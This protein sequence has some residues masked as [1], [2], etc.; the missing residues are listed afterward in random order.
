MGMLKNYLLKIQERVT[1]H[2]FG[3][4]AIEHAAVSGAIKITGSLEEDV[5]RFAQAYDQIC[6]SYRNWATRA[7]QRGID[8]QPTAP[9][10][11]LNIGGN[12]HLSRPARQRRPVA[13][14][15]PPAQARA[16]DVSAEG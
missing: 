13:V 4:E 10:G 3:Q 6:E 9:N 11:K 1:E 5:R 8:P 16:L 12:P 7:P 2:Q 15:K 14:R